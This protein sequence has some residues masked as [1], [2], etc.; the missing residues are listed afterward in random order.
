[1]EIKI[2][3]KNDRMKKEDEIEV[4]IFKYMF[5]CFFLCFVYLKCK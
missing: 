3:H 2:Q 4:N 5:S 1:M